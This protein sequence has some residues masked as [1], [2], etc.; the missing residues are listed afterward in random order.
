MRNSDDVTSENYAVFDGLVIVGLLTCLYTSVHASP[1]EVDT[2]NDK[3]V[4]DQLL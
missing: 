3:I 2:E 1:V 4:L